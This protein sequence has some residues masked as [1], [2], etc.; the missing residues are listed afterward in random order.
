MELSVVFKYLL[1]VAAFTVLALGIV[2]GKGNI[3]Q[4]VNEAKSVILRYVVYAVLD[5]GLMGLSIALVAV[6]KS[7]EANIYVTTISMWIFDYVTAW[8]LLYLCLK[9]GEDLTL[10]RQYRKGYDM[11]KRKSPFSGFISLIVL[12]TKG[13][14]WDGPEKFVEFWYIEINSNSK[15]LMVLSLGSLIQAIFWTTLYWLGFELI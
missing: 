11:I 7:I 10:G 15:R 13:I 12:I 4:K 6:M 3:R 8:S 9:T 2:L 14:I 1:V 5:F